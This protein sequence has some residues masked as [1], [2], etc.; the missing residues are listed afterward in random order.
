MSFSTAA[1]GLL[2]TG[3]TDKK[4]KLWDVS[5]NQP[6]LIASQDLQVGFHCVV[7]SPPPTDSPLNSKIGAVF[8]ACFCGQAGYLLACGGAMGSVTVW[9]MRSLKAA[10]Q[11]W[12]E[13]K[14]M[15]LQPEAILDDEEGEA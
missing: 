10:T 1:P 6:S 12:P 7:P 11:K 15:G 5:S 2:A 9:D 4:V 14:K 8:T 13:L 3:S